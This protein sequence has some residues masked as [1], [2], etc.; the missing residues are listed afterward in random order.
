MYL[1]YNEITGACGGVIVM[2]RTCK[3]KKLAKFLYIIKGKASTLQNC[4]KWHS[5][6]N[7][8]QARGDNFLTTMEFFLIFYHFTGTGDVIPKIFTGKDTDQL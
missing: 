2:V 5:T 6:I 8:Y 1:K 3:V 7:F 4:K